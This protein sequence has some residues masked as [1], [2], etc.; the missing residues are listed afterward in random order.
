MKVKLI[1]LIVFQLVLSC[2]F[3]VPV[4][5]ASLFDAP[6]ESIFN[7]DSLGGTDGYAESFGISG[8]SVSDNDFNQE[9]LPEITTD[10]IPEI[11]AEDIPAIISLQLADLYSVNEAAA[12]NY[13]S[14]TIVSVFDKVVNG[15]K[16]G[17]NYCAWRDQDNDSSSGYLII[18]KGSVNG[19]TLY[20]E[21][22]AQLC[23]YYRTYTGSASSYQYYYSVQTTTQ[24]YNISVNNRLVYTDMLPG[25]P[26]LG[27]RSDTP[28]NKSLIIIGAIVILVIFM[29]GRSKK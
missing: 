20:F 7:D 4:R 2:S 12:N 1:S 5:A 13:L 15:A 27:S 14:T 19:S 22:G 10:D 25:Y 26:S 18:G 28:A 9:D 29:L 23:H 3:A 17:T 6:D 8:V 11:T 16:L 21:S 24:Q